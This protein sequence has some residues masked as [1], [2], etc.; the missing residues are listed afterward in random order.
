MANKWS[1]VMWQCLQTWHFATPKHRCRGLVVL[2]C[3][4]IPQC[5]WTDL[6]RNLCNRLFETPKLSN[7][8]GLTLGHLQVLCK[9]IWAFFY[10]YEHSMK[11]TQT[12]EYYHRPTQ[13]KFP[14]FCFLSIVQH[15]WIWQNVAKDMT[16]CSLDNL[17]S[18]TKATCHFNC[19]HMNVSM[20][21]N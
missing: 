15:C 18:K 5:K 13:S 20:V 16:H 11:S 7:M 21:A 4:M 10:E 12:L 1:N 19:I 9:V 2:S 14:W 17:K 6:Y 8:A 3:W